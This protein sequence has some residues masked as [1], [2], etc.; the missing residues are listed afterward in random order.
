MARR[1]KINFRLDP[2]WLL[3]EPVD[4]EYNKYTL[5]DYLQKCQ[6]GFDKLELYPDFVELSLHLANL[7]TLSKHK[8]I[9]YT[10]KKFDSCDDEILVKELV[11]K[12]T[13][14]LTDT[15]EE[16]LEKTIK[17]SGVMLFDA[18]NVAKAIWNL[19]FDAIEVNVRKNKSEITSGYGFVFY[20]RKDASILYVWEYKVKKVKDYVPNSKLELKQIYEG[21]MALKPLMEIINESS[22]FKRDVL[23]KD[24]PIFEVKSSTHFPMEQT[25]VPMI[26]RKVLSTYLQFVSFENTVQFDL[27]P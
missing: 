18:F 17:Y 21:D 27:L 19:A 5:L 7:Q 25:L 22:T 20:W 8:K 12:D 23:N 4:F 11:S 10:D 15:E 13:R 24:L 14:S 6:K 1:K 26:K 9:F 3:K 2:E 16:E